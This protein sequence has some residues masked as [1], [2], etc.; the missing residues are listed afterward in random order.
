MYTFLQAQLESPTRNDWGQTIH[1][2]MEIFGLELTLE[3]IKEM[4]DE[5]FKHLVKKRN[6]KQVLNI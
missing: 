6:L 4:S 1:S 3:E 5:S 2:D